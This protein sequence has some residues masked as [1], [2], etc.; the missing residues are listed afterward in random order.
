MVGVGVDGFDPK[1]TQ[2]IE[3]GGNLGIFT[4]SGEWWRLLTATFLHAGIT[5][6]AFNV[7]GMWAVGR[8]TEQI[9]RPAAYALIYFGSGLIASLTSLLW[10]PMVV[11]VGASGALLGI[12]GAFF[13]FTIRRRDVLPEPFVKSVRRNALIL[14]VLN[15]GISVMVPNVDVA[16]H[17]GGL[18]TGLGLGYLI[19]R[20]AERPAAT[21]EQGLAWRRKALLANAGIV[22]ALLGL[23]ILAVPAQIGAVGQAM[24]LDEEAGDALDAAG[25]DEDARLEA[26]EDVAL[27]AMLELEAELEGVEGDMAASLLRYASLLRESYEREIAGLRDQNPV[28]LLEARRLREEASRVVIDPG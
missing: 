22:V 11:S 6:L 19:A 17:L 9:F 16:A 3:W 25:D 10:S 23:G 26:L 8:I 27:P 14:I 2:L 28:D 4:A 7:Y 12:L 5:H 1:P 24:R 15:V 18:G 13:G 21:R 20:M